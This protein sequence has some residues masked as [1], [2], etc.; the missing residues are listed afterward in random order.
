MSGVV[1]GG[2]DDGWL[3]VVI[4]VNEKIFFIQFLKSVWLF[5]C[6]LIFF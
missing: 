4:R 1:F 3:S 2:R 6:F 5:I